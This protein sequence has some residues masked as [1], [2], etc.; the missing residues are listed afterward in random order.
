MTRE[1]TIKIFAREKDCVQQALQQCADGGGYVSPDGMIRAAD[2]VEALTVGIDAL[3]AQAEVEKNEPLTAEELRGM[4][5]EPV[6]WWNT[7]QKP[8]CT[9]C[10]SKKYIPQPRFVT[11]DFAVEDSVKIVS[12]KRMKAWGYRP[13]RRKPEE[14]TK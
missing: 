5:G 14:G 1:E 9:L 6:W 8:I 10:I 7:T 4:D 11:Y 12:L 2:Y 3:C 13:Y